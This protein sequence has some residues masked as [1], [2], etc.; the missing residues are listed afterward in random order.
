MKNHNY[1]LSTKNILVGFI[2][3]MSLFISDLYS[4]TALQFNGLLDEHV[5]VSDVDDEDFNFGTGD[6]TIEA[7]IRTTEEDLV[8]AKNI[9]P[10]SS[11]FQRTISGRRTRLNEYLDEMLVPQD[12]KRVG[13]WSFRYVGS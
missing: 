7:W 4:Q 13:S 6:F 8:V 9:F 12:L 3:I 5:I 2:A 11:G 10:W 1:L